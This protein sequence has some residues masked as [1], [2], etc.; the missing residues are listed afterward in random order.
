MKI[1][2]IEKRRKFAKIEKIKFYGKMQK[3][4][5]KLD[6]APLKNCLKKIDRPIDQSK[7]TW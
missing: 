7:P 5:A 4:N 2:R 6:L 1:R 3:A